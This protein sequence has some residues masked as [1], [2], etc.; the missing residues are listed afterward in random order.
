MC[1]ELNTKLTNPPKFLL[2]VDSG[3]PLLS[4]FVGL[5]RFKLLSHGV[6]IMCRELALDR[7]DTLSP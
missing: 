6:G 3:L 4:S 5:F 2:K 7:T 1:I